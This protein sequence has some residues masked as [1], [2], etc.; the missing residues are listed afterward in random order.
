VI[1]YEI[2]RANVE[3]MKLSHRSQYKQILKKKNFSLSM[4]P[5][6]T[7]VDSFLHRYDLTAALDF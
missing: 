4:R 6:V 7:K 2:Y 3:K 1:T 5:R